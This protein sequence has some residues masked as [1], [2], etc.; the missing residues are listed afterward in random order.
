MNNTLRLKGHFG[1]SKAQHPGPPSLPT[2]AVV[3]TDQIQDRIDDLHHVIAYWKTQ[4]SF[5]DPLVEVRYRT[6]VAKSNRIKR[7][8]SSHNKSAND[9]IVGAVFSNNHAG[10]PCH[11]ITHYVKME[12]IE[13]TLRELEAAKKILVHHGNSITNEELASITHD[14]LAEIDARMGLSKTSFAQIIR[15]VYYVER[16]TVKN[17]IDP[18]QEHAL[19]TIYDTGRNGSQTVE[20]LNRLGVDVLRANLLD[21]TT[22]NMAPDQYRR[23]TETAPYLVAMSLKDALELKFEPNFKQV[24]DLFT[25]SIPMPTNEPIVGVIDTCFDLKNAYFSEWVEYHD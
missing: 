16:F 24:D 23:L 14:G 6:I 4:P 17:Y 25:P 18:Q 20:L 15:D 11:V 21:A 12:T 9:S 13:S 7:L 10:K 8:L 19:V 1:H 5:I 2:N 3:T 22:I